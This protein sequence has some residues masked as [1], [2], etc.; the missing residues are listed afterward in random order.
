[1]TKKTKKFSLNEIHLYIFPIEGILTRLIERGPSAASY[2]KLFVET[3]SP[4]LNGKSGGPV[5]D[6]SGV[7]WGVQS[8]TRHLSLGFNPEVP[9]EAGGSTKHEEHQFLNVGRAAHPETIVGLLK[10]NGVP[11]RITA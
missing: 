8:Q 10:E 3:S 4:G 7:V 9:D 1:M 5:L 6:T 2:R 11:H